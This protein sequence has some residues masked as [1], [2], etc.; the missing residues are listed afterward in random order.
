[1]QLIPAGCAKQAARVED[2]VL[3]A[4][5]LRFWDRSLA[6][7]AFAAADH[8]QIVVRTVGGSIKLVVAAAPKARVADLAAEVLRMEEFAKCLR[9]LGGERE[10]ERRGGGG[11]ELPTQ[12]G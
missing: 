4:Y 5:G 12:P 10:R 7:V 1:L 11:N 9:V 2:I 6:L 8:G 3:H